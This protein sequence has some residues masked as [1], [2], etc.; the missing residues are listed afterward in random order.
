MSDF[1]IFCAVFLPNF[2]GLFLT[3]G[4]FV[5]VLPVHLLNCLMSALCQTGICTNLPDQAYSD[6]MLAHFWARSRSQLW[7]LQAAAFQ[8]GIYVRGF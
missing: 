3:N 6:S 8:K 7:C 2:V 4:F 5:V 1:T